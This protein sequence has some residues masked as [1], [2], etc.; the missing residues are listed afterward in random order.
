M[1][2]RSPG[3]V[4]LLETDTVSAFVAGVLRVT[5]AVVEPFSAM[6]LLAR[7]TLKAGP[8]LSVTVI[9][10]VVAVFGNGIGEMASDN[11]AVTT[12]T[13]S[14]VYKIVLHHINRERYIGQIR[15]NYRRSRNRNRRADRGQ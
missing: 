14:P 13:R 15:R 1:R 4:K 2:G 3:L 9:D 5:V 7:L 11:C 8:L 12:A 6:V 10:A